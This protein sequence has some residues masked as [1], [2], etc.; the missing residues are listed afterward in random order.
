[1]RKYSCLG[2][3]E[4]RGRKG[5]KLPALVLL[6]VLLVLSPVLYEAAAICIAS[7]KT[8]LGSYTVVETP[9]LSAIR[10]SWRTGRIEAASWL[11]PLT[12]SY[13]W[14]ASVV[15]PFFL[16]WTMIAAIPLKR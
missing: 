3:D 13:P 12:H 5:S 1:M 8:A 6:V 11:Y 2:V 4:G 16:L 15:V 10:E 9:V 7:W 14:K